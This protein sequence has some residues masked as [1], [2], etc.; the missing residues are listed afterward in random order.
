MAFLRSVRTISY[1]DESAEI[2]SNS[3][4]KDSKVLSE[5]RETFQIFTCALQ[6]P[7]D[8][9]DK[10]IDNHMSS[11]RTLSR[12]GDD[13]DPSQFR[14]ILTT[15]HTDYVSL[16]ILAVDDGLDGLQVRDLQGEWITDEKIDKNS[17]A[18]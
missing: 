4:V 5:L 3:K 8:Y 9:F 16:T 12:T 2:L 11:L 1:G 14:R 6:L 10:K 15:A 17:H 18:L 7:K 13:A